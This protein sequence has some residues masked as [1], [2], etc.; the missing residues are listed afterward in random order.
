MLSNTTNH[1]NVLSLNYVDIMFDYGIRMGFSEDAVMDAI[2][3]VFQ[4]LLEKKSPLDIEN[5]KSY[6]IK[7]VRNELINESQRVQNLD[8]TEDGDLPF[9]ITVNIEEMLIDADFENTIQKKI[10]HVLKTLTPRQR[11]IIYLRYTGNYSYAEIAEILQIS[12][13][14]C[15]NLILKALKELRKHVSTFFYLMIYLNHKN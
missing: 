2:H 7:S 4:R 15:R 14:A 8:S 12:I 10:Q 9:S 6:L 13:P 11:E 3:N 1:I 5:E